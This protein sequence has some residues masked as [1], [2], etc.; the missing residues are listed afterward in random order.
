[1]KPGGYI[2]HIEVE[3][4]PRCDDGTLPTPNVL[5]KCFDLVET[6]NGVGGNFSVIDQIKPQLAEAGFV[7][8]VEHRYKLPLGPWSSNPMYQDL[9]RYY[10]M[11]WRTGVQGWLMGPLTRNLGWTPSQVNEMAQEAFKLMDA[12]EVHVYYEAVVMYARKPEE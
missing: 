3:P 10:E 5:Q 1:M 11:F 6:L 9:G 8:I 12:R 4:K 7:D 2:Q